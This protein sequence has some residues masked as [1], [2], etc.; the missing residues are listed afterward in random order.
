MS[1][2]SSYR[3]WVDGILR[4]SAI[5]APAPILFPAALPVLVLGVAGIRHPV[6]WSV[7]LAWAIA[8]VG[9]GSWR[10]W[11]ILRVELSNADHQ[12]ERETRFRLSKEYQPTE[13]NDDRSG[14]NGA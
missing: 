10:Y 2:Y 4:D 14:D 7:V 1:V 12:Y 8:A 13:S 6:A 5:R 11:R 9:W 3:D